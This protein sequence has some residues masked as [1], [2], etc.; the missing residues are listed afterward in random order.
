MNMLTYTGVSI[1]KMLR[2][3]LLD[4]LL[5]FALGCVKA[6]RQ[7]HQPTR[8]QPQLPAFATL[9]PG[10]VAMEFVLV[11]AG[12]F[13][14]GSPSNE[15]DHDII[16]TQ[17]RVTLTKDYWIG[18]YEVTQEQYA[19][20]M[21]TNPAG[22]KKGGRYPVG[23]V[24]WNDAMDF[25]RKLTKRE[26]AAG[27]LPAGYEYTLPTEAQWEYAARGGHNSRGF[28]YSGGNSLNDVAWY[29]ENAGRKR[30]NDSSG[31]YRQALSNGNS[32]HEVGTKQPNEL[33]LYDMSGNV[34]EWCRDWFDF[35]S[36]DAT[37]P[38][39]SATVSNRVFRGGSWSDYA[40]GC[41]VAYRF[42]L[43]PSYRN[44]DL[45][46]RVALAPVR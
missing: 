35:Y 36:G 7:Y 32:A 42:S 45:G 13:L 1:R 12:T 11:K 19:A 34:W 21:G 33:G 39:G 41:R 44:S 3:A 37:D 27:R 31:D 15:P 26:R 5:F 9:L 38:K 22:F 6:G 24:S 16:E 4:C 8:K 29:Y 10:N 40:W 30:L 18:K 28:V 23:D 25:C 14:M 17:H 43:D 46:F 20:L 2:L